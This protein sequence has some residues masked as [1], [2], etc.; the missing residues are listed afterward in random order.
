MPTEAILNYLSSHEELGKLQLH[1]VMQCAPVLKKLK[2]S[3]I[4]MVPSVHTKDVLNFF[5]STDISAV[6]LSRGGKKDVIFIYRA[7]WLSSYLSRR[8][9]REFLDQYGYHCQNVEEYIAVLAQRVTYFHQCQ[10]TFPHEMGVF[11][12]YP[13]EDVLGF[14]R[15]SGKSFKMSG[16]WKVYGNVKKTKKLF[17]AFDSARE[18]A[19]EE[20]FSGKKVY[21]IA[22]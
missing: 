14:I 1:V 4:L 15:Y 7:G 20:L 12:G 3:G 18:Q 16:Y 19:V 22:Y 6:V 21:E 9:V 10:Q 5:R 11:L 17:E 8:E 13:M 2:M